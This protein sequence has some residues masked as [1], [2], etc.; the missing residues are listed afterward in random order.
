MCIFRPFARHRRAPF[1]LVHQQRSKEIMV[2]KNESLSG[3]DVWQTAMA[4]CVCV[5]VLRQA[6]ASLPHTK[7]AL[8]PARALA[9]PDDALRESVFFLLCFQQS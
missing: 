1:L 6:F 8:I 9:R 5:C 2:K 3:G 4:E 7:R